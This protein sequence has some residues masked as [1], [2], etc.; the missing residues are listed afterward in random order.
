MHRYAVRKIAYISNFF[1]SFCQHTEEFSR[2]SLYL[3][4]G[5]VGGVQFLWLR[6]AGISKKLVGTCSF[7]PNLPLPPI[8]INLYQTLSFIHQLTQNMTTDFLRIYP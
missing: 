4:Y 7:G 2:N 5:Y 8:K 1:F 6:G 3:Q